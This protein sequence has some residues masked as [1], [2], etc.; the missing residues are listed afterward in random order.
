MTPG[1][2]NRLRIP[3]LDANGQKVF[4]TELVDAAGDAAGPRR[5]I[6]AAQFEVE[7]GESDF[8]TSE[9]VKL[10][11]QKERNDKKRFID[12]KILVIFNNN[13]R[14]SLARSHHAI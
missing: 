12:C 9:L 8:S 14:R 2:G 7:T 1:G 11:Q 13:Y 10:Y 3:R 4:S 5:R 6:I